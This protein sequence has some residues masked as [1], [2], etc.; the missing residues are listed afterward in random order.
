MRHGNKINHLGRTTG[1]RLALLRNLSCALITH[2]RISTTLAKAKELRTF[3]EPLITKA[4]ANTT[5]T[6]R[7]V[8]GS[9]QNK[10]AV[11][12]LFDVISEK[13]GDRPGGYTRV[14]KTGFRK[15]DAA[16]MC[17][18]ELVDYNEAMLKTSGDKEGTAKRTRRSRSKKADDN[19]T[20]TA[21]PTIEA[22]AAEAAAPEADAAE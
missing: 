22:P 20:E 7:M 19:A 16:E 8:F 4:K 13:V 17:I 14:L 2:K 11:K 15:G 21:T 3:V 18:I 12:E 10:E 1:H 6:R 5:H 9:L